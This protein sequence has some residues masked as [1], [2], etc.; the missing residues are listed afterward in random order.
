MDTI[1][2]M[3]SIHPIRKYPIVLSMDGSWYYY[4]SSSDMIDEVGVEVEFEVDDHFAYNV[5][6]IDQEEGNGDS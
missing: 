2:G 3:T 6:P 4:G 1:K 5:R